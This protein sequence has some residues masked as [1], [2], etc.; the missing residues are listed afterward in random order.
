MNMREEF[1]LAYVEGLVRRCGEGFRSTALCSLT[2][3][4][5]DGEYRD[6][7][8]FIAWWAWQASRESLVIELP[9]AKNI[10][11][12][13]ADRESAWDVCKDACIDA[14]EAAGLKVKL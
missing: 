13:D 10:L 3:K 12:H 9:R 11:P 4:R 2:E 1:E 7:T 5:P 8:D 14:I 6:Y